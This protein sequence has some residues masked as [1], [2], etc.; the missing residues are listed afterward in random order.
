MVLGTIGGA[1]GLLVLAG[2]AFVILFLCI[3][4]IARRRTRDEGI[5]WLLLVIVV[6]CGWALALYSMF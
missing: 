4:M 3:Q 1:G 2:T 5:V 6:A